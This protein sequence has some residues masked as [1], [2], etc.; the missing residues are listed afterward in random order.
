M[1]GWQKSMASECQAVGDMKAM[2]THGAAEPMIHAVG[3]AILD[4]TCLS[5]TVPCF[6]LAYTVLVMPPIMN[7]ASWLPTS[8]LTG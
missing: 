4:H 8:L 3:H 2:Q 1:L 6:H 5:A 7:V